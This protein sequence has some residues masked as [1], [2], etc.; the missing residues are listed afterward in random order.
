M[1]CQRLY[2]VSSRFFLS[3][4]FL[5]N[6]RAPWS[7]LPLFLPPPSTAQPAVMRLRSLCGCL[8][9]PSEEAVSNSSLSARTRTGPRSKSTYEINKQAHLFMGTYSSRSPGRLAS[10]S[11]SSSLNGMRLPK[12]HPWQAPL[13]PPAPHRVLPGA[14][15]GSLG[16]ILPWAG[17]RESGSDRGLPEHPRTVASV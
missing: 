17:R 7:L 14:L 8:M 2:F 9:F 10:G 16:N 3:P 4:P 11:H 13:R 5:P 12:S 6:E 1:R 15:C